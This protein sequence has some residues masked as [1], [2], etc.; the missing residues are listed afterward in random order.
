MRCPGAQCLSVPISGKA[1][2]SEWARLSERGTEGQD[3]PRFVGV[4]SFRCAC[5]ENPNSL[6]TF[7]ISGTLT[8]QVLVLT[9]GDAL[10]A[11]SV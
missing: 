8:L 9:G 11:E 2:G 1:R 6:V 3:L 5:S 4:G 10:G 7:W